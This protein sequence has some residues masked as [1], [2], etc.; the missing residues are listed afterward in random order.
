MGRGSRAKVRG[1]RAGA[2]RRGQEAGKEAGKEAARG[3]GRGGQG[4]GLLLRARLDVLLRPVAEDLT[5]GRQHRALPTAVSLDFLE[6]VVGLNHEGGH[7][8]YE[9]LQA[10]CTEVQ[11]GYNGSIIREVTRRLVQCGA[12]Q[13]GA[14]R[15]ARCT[16]YV[17]HR[18]I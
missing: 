2:A 4:G 13:C 5:L 15:T 9:G 3:Q 18:R 11:A 1:G 14:T 8:R 7:L 16:I 17:L 6:L 10:G 12:V